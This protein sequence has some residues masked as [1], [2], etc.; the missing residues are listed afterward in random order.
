VPSPGSIG[1]NWGSVSA[2]PSAG[3]AAS[4]PFGLESWWG[5]YPEK[6]QLQE[7]GVLDAELLS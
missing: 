7:V 1:I 3:A 5:N 4:A 2:A 6:E